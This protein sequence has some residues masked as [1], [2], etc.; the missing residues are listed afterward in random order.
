MGLG[1]LNKAKN[2]LGQS[3]N[4]SAKFVA[5]NWDTYSPTTFLTADFITSNKTITAGNESLVGEHIIPPQTEEGY[6]FGTPALPY[7]Q[8]VVYMDLKDSAT[9]PVSVDGVI[10]LV[11]SDYRGEETREV[12]RGNLSTLRQGASDITKRIKFPFTNK[13][14]KQNDRLRIYFTPKTAGNGTLSSANSIL[15]IAGSLKSSR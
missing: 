10:R 13:T 4:G 6:G 15:E 8:G 11:V 5:G 2:V 7:N 14:G 9:T 1:L 3:S 12:F